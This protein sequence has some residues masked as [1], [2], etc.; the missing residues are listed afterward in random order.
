MLQNFIDDL[1]VSTGVA[2]RMT[3]L[4]A[5][6][7]IA[8]FITLTFL[9]AA[10]FSYV[11]QQYGIVPAC[12][13]GAAFFFVVTLIVTGI[14][15]YRR[16]RTRRAVEAA[17]KANTKSAFATVMS[18]P[19]MM[20]AGLQIVRAVGVKRLLPLLAV[21]GIAFGLMAQR[22]APEEDPAE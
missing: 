6:I 17:A 15:L 20:A 9:C 19:M 12:L 18:D 1:K 11:L 14:Y 5:A 7:S 22:K 2:L 16:R 10:A 4:I 8:L 21:G 13:S 3:A